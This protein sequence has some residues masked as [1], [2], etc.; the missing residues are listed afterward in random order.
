MESLVVF[1]TGERFATMTTT[2]RGQIFEVS[3]DGR[4][5][6]VTPRSILDGEPCA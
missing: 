5:L 1:E 6:D 2:G 4:P 3:A